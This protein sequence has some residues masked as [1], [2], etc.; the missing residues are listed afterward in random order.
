M[1]LHLRAC[2]FESLVAI[3]AL[4]SVPPAAGQTPG[5]VP[6]TQ[7][8]RP[9]QAQQKI[10]TQAQA[11]VR[12]EFRTAL[13]PHG[14]WR[15]SS[16]W[17][18]VWV[19]ASRPRDWRPY[20]VGHWVYTNDW[21]W[22]WIEDQSEAAWGVVVFH[23]GRWVLEDGV[24]VWIPGDVWGPGWV[25]W[26]YGKASGERR[27]GKQRRQAR[28][29]IVREEVYIGWAP[30]PPE[31]IVV[32]IWERPEVWIFVRAR[33]FTAPV[34]ARVIL[35][36]D[37][38][39]I[40][41][42]ETVVANRTV[43]LEEHRVAVAPGIPPTLIASAIGRP[44]RSFD[45]QPRVLVGTVDFPGAVVVRPEDVRTQQI[46]RLR[47]SVRQT[48]NEI[49]PSNRV[50]ELQALRPGEQGRIF[51]GAPRAVQRLKGQPAGQAPAAGGEQPST[52]GRA[53]VQ[54]GKDSIRSQQQ[55]GNERV[56][57]QRQGKDTIQPRRQQGQETIRPKQQQ[58]QTQG[59]DLDETSKDRGPK[60]RPKELPRAD[61]KDG[62][63]KKGTEGRGTPQQRNPKPTPKDEPRWGTEGRGS[64]RQ[65]EQP[66][67][68]RLQRDP[69]KGAAPQRSRKAE[70]RSGTEGRGGMQEP[71]QPSRQPLQRDLP[72][73]AAP[74]P[75]SRADPRPGTEGRRAPPLQQR[76]APQP[77]PRDLP[78]AATPKAP[79]PPATEGRGGQSRGTAPVAPPRPEPK[80]VNPQPKRP[81]AP[82][83]P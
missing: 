72:K 39:E 54:Q 71:Q 60:A 32:E 66:P 79:L 13:E 68:Q 62:R 10:Q 16:R 41:I 49:R 26:R 77:P 7:A 50:P 27:A 48:G 43:V 4:A 58:P 47:T 73:G 20:T 8:Q 21:G 52:E 45:V 5:Q 2:V 1:T 63:P 6:Q 11:S 30:L 37:E 29:Q 19:P 83:P 25:N 51:D 57:P 36:P 65:P 23:Y 28:T 34:I 81:G 42:R 78:K 31:E 38:V 70:P 64:V 74:Q 12:A 80:S 3:V 35:P 14:H 33:D 56:Q 75:A 22:Y 55:Q 44:I 69:P 67:Q 53:P 17:G 82:L 40:A 9:E 15:T 61:Q 24:W 59:R 76:S 18:D 46:Q